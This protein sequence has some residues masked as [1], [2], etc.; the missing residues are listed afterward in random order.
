MEKSTGKVGEFCQSGKV[1]TMLVCAQGVITLGPACNGF[2]YYEHP[3][4]TNTIFF[5]EKNT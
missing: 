2:G 5:S 3:A 4:T 1:G